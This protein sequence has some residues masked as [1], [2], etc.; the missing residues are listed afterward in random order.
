MQLQHAIHLDVNQ[1]QFCCQIKA[2]LTYLAFYLINKALIVQLNDLSNFLN[3]KPYKYC[4]LLQ[5]ILH[6]SP[7]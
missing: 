2:Q 5:Q 3:R 1:S 6:S 4:I 7:L